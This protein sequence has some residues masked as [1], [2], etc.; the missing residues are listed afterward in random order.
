MLRLA[1]SSPPP[2]GVVY[3]AGGAA[4][5]LRGGGAEG[6]GAYCPGSGEGSFPCAAASVVSIY[7]NTPLQPPPGGSWGLRATLGEGRARAAVTAALGGEGPGLAA[8][9]CCPGRAGL[10]WC[11]GEEGASCRAPASPPACGCCI[12]AAAAAGFFPV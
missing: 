5:S 6:K 7:R 4:G 2:P 9:P 1:G 10:T 11:R 3:V 8:C 12:A